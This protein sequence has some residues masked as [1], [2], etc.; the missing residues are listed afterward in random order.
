MVERATPQPLLL[1][2]PQAAQLLAMSED[3]FEANVMP[4]IKHIRRGRLK[5]YPISELERWV[6]L[7]SQ[8]LLGGR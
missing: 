1:R 4:E 7:N 8:L 3:F 2:K 6:E 5:L